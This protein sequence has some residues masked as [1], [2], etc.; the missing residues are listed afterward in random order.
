VA[1]AVV[2][3]ISAVEVAAVVVVDDME[4]AA[5]VGVVSARMQKQSP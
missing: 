3:V 5:H 2:E 1:E 4:G